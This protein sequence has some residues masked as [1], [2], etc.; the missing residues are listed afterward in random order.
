MLIH[1]KKPDGRKVSLEFEPNQKVK[2]IK[3]AIEKLDGLKSQDYRL[4]YSGKFIK[5]ELT[6]Q[7]ANIIPGSFLLLKYKEFL[8]P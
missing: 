1:I 3:D 6:L 5:E 7:E 8:G 4:I 2:E